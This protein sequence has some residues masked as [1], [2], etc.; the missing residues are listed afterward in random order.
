MSWMCCLAFRCSPYLIGLQPRL[1]EENG[2]LQV[3]QLDQNVFDIL[4]HLELCKLG[5]EDVTG[6]LL[7]VVDLL[8]HP[9]DAVRGIK[10]DHRKDLTI[11]WTK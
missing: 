5:R 2:V 7:A 4:M 1:Q 6:G 8:E 3:S 10:L 9:E 11:A